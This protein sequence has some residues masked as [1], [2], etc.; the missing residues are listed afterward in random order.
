MPIS[1]RR[2]QN[3]NAVA[4]G[5]DLHPVICAAITAANVTII[6]RVAQAAADDMEDHSGSENSIMALWRIHRDAVRLLHESNFANAD[7]IRS[8]GQHTLERIAECVAELKLMQRQ[9]RQVGEGQ[10]DGE[11]PTSTLRR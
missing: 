3:D 6:T 9:L 8:V 7:I 4:P 11:D 2:M 10:T 1:E 5:G